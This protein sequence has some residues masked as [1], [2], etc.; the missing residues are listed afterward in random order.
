MR[1]NIL[2]IMADQFNA[3][4]LGAAGGQ[5][6][7]PALDSLAARGTRAI[8]SELAG[9]LEQWMHQTGDPLLDGPV[10]QRAYRDRI[11]EFIAVANGRRSQPA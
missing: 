6:R 8:V 10:A 11:G 2:W 9:R 1:P 5:V 4:C 3:G 7:T